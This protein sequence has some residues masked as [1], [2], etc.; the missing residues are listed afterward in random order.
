MKAAALILGLALSSVGSAQA[1]LA[2]EVPDCGTWVRQDVT[3]HRWWL[4][5]FISGLNSALR[6]EVKED[7]LRGVKGDQVLLWMDNYCKANPLKNIHDGTYKLYEELR[8]RA[9]IK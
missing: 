9:G 8:Q 3:G 2:Y 4:L 6:H 7:P 1:A 5:G